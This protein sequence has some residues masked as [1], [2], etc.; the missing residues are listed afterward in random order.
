MSTSVDVAAGSE[1]VLPAGGIPLDDIVGSLAGE[2]K[3]TLI[4]VDA[5]RN[6]PRISRAMG[7]KGRGFRP[8]DPVRGGRLFI[9]LSTRF[10]DTADDGVAGRGSPFARAFSAN[11]QTPGIRIDDAFRR[12]R[13]AVGSETGDKQLPRPLSRTGGH[14]RIDRCWSSSSRLCCQ[15]RLG[16]TAL[17]SNVVYEYRPSRTRSGVDS[18]RQQILEADI[19]IDLAAHA[20]G[21]DVDDLSAVLRRINVGAERPLAERRIH[22]PDDPAGDFGRVGVGGLQS[23]KTF[24]RLLGNPGIGACFVFRH[25]RLVGRLA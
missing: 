4:F 5:C 10:G 11:I 14:P 8:L 19:A 1:C 13:D 6:D 16:R 22:D 23:G 18:W 9:G 20:V 2:A 24:Q 25:A 21:H 17:R 12:L 7:A 15:L 3:A